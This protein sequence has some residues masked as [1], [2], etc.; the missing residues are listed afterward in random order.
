MQVAPAGGYQ[1]CQEVTQRAVRC[2]GV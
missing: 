2:Q 1:E